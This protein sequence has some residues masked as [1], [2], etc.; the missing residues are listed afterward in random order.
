[1]FARRMRIAR[2]DPADEKTA[3]A[4][5]EVHRAASE[6]DDP[7]EPPMSA[8]TFRVFLDEG[9]DHNPGES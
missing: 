2:W 7:V 6:R 3:L 1:M 5:H 8:G 9:F 4:C